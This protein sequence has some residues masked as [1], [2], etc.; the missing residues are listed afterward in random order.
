MSHAHATFRGT[1]AF[2]LLSLCIALTGCTNQ[3]EP[4][5]KAIAGIEAAI[6]S[7]GPD[8]QRYIPDDL[9]AVNDQLAG[10]K[11]KFDQKDYA[12]VIAGAPA[13]LAQAQGLVAAKDTAVRAATAREA[14]EKQ[15]AEQALKTDWESLATAVP[16]AITAIDSRVTILAK[17]K[18]LPANVTKDALASAQANLAD[19]KSLW[20]QAT[21]AQSG[22]TLADAVMAAQQAKEKTDAALAGLGMNPG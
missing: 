5:K 22:G 7:V 20:A 19:A 6:A 14:A 9:K 2:L 16:A 15:A 13:L 12:A 21:T 8:A 11:A 4:A 1:A 3:M 10:L 17:S 18:K